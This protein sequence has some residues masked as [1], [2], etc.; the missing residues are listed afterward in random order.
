[1]KQHRAFYSGLVAV[2]LGCAVSGVGS[3]APR[4]GA[5]E[6]LVPAYMQPRTDAKG[7]QWNLSN[8]GFL[9]NH[10]NAFYNNL[11][12]LHMNGQQF[13]CYQ[14]QMTADGKE[15][16]LASQ[17]PMAGMQVIR[18]IRLLEKEGLMRYVD[19]F[20]NS[21]TVPLTATVEYRNNF[22]SPLKSV[23]TDRGT[24][25]PS[26][27]GKGETGLVISPRQNTQQAVA[28]V[29]GAPHGGV[30]PTFSQRGQY[31]CHIAFSLTVP[32]GESVALAYAVAQVPPPDQDNAA[33]ARLFKGLAPTKFMKSIR[34]EELAVLVNF[35]TSVGAEPAAFLTTLGVASLGLERGT[36]DVLALGEKTRLTGKTNGSVMV[37]LTPFGEARL[38]L[39]RIAALTGAAHEAGVPRIF[40]RDGQVFSGTFTAEDWRFL[41]PSGAQ[42]DLDFASLDRLVRAAAPDENKWD[43]HTVAMLATHHGMQLALEGVETPLECTTSWGP[44]TFTLDDLQWCLPAEDGM[45]GHLVQ[46]KDGSRFFG[47]LSGPPVTVKTRLFGSQAFAAAQIRGVV[48][49]SALA[50]PKGEEGEDSRLARTHLVLAGNQVLPGQI[51]A[52]EVEILTGSKIVRVPPRG[53]R[54]LRNVSEENEAAAREEGS[55]PFEVE[56]WGGGVMTGYLREPVLTVHVRDARWRVPAS[57][58]MEFRNPA[59]VLSDE[60]RMRL[61]ELVRGLGSEDWETREASSQG[62]AELGV[63]ARPTLEET[64]KTTTDP[65]VK[66]RVER[67]LES[68]E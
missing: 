61:A 23:V 47:F 41:M 55:P 26:T 22:S 62:L 33:L 43:P 49:A 44:L 21:G 5:P 51:E 68:M 24:V 9:Q 10:G 42:V 59:P 25:N 53:I 16:V 40:L 39:E 13:Y 14:P 3:A 63:L 32:A 35:V 54:S 15:L 6:V 58:I 12:V 7:G 8:Y 60:V 28:F 17:Q 50:S 64:L 37:A 18:R 19:I 67:L 45:V 11:L 29:L 57:D 2:C 30:R 27:L 1:M 31:E 4:T 46:F 52:D 36:T 66:H 65:E 38:P 20:Q 48:T 34:R 56:L